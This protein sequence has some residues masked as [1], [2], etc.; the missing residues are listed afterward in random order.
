[1]RTTT[2]NKKEKKKEKNRQTV[3]SR[4]GVSLHITLKNNLVRP[5]LAI[6]GLAAVESELHK[7]AAETQLRMH[8]VFSHLPRSF[9]RT[10]L[11]YLAS[12]FVWTAWCRMHTSANE[13][14]FGTRS[15]TTMWLQAAAFVTVPSVWRSCQMTTAC[16]PGNHEREN[17]VS[18]RDSSFGGHPG[19]GE[20][21]ARPKD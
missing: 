3:S 9:W 5:F 4:H 7:N 11:H 6:R 16:R 8:K 10:L 13:T 15:Q 2:D 18:V 21:L 1:M 19:Q 20:R 14:V 12:A 17:A